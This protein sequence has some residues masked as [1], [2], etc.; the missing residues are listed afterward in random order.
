MSFADKLRDMFGGEDW[1]ERDNEFRSHHTTAGRSDYERHRPA[2]QYGYAAAYNP[3]YRGKSFDQVETSL[4][5]D[6]QREHADVGE[7]DSFRDSARDA[8]ARG[9]ERVLTLSEEELAVGKRK[10]SAGEVNVHKRVETEHVTEKVPLT[11]EEVTIERRPVTDQ[12]LADADLGEDHITVQLTEEEAVVQKRPVVKEEIVV[13]KRAVQDTQTV[14]ADLKRERAE[15]DDTTR[16][17]RTTRDDLRDE[18]GGR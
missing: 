11:R 8:Y 6:W 16:T 18:A 7:W 17:R 12:R 10:V 2:Y 13:T 14:E 9:Q 3:D 1:N 15:I 4:Q 5:T